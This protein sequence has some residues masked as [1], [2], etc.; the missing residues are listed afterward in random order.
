LVFEEDGVYHL[1]Y[2]GA[3]DGGWRACLATSS[4]LIHWEKRGS[5]LTLGEEGEMDAAGACSPWVILEDG[6]WHMFYLGTPNGREVP[7]FPYLTLKARS[8]ALGGPWEKQRDIIPFSTQAGT[9]RSH[10]ASP[11]HIV[12]VGEEYMQFFSASTEDAPN[13]NTRRTLSIARTKDLNGAWEVEAEP[14]VPLAEQIENSSLYFERENDTWFLFTNHIGIEDGIEYTD[15]IWVY[16][17]KDLNVW[18]PENKAVVLDGENCTWSRR[19]IGMPSV[20]EM[21]GRLAMLYDAPGGDSIAH[22]NRDIG[23]AWFDL[24]LVP[25]V[26]R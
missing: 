19:C 13:V 4:D 5:A 17:T 20:I 23:L 14:L 24:P 7:A 22:L 11:G 1:F 15:A 21:D 8:R 25:P 26:E 18:D 12:K 9:Y 2:D 10:T 3:A 16:W 6:W